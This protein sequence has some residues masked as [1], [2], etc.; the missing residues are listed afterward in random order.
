MINRDEERLT[1]VGRYMISIKPDFLPEHYQAR[2]EYTF[3]LIEHTLQRFELSV[4]LDFFFKTI[5]FAAIIGN[6][7]RHQEN[8][9]FITKTTNTTPYEIANAIYSKVMRTAPIYDS[10]SSLARE[11]NDERVSVM[12]SNEEILFKYINNGNSEIHWNKEKI[13][14]FKLIENLLN[15]AHNLQFRKSADFIANWDDL[16]IKQI[17]NAIDLN[18]SGE[19]KYYCIPRERKELIIKLLAIRAQKL[20]ELIN[21]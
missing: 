5:L 9:A 21:G 15:S 1:E 3:Q 14:H 10:G 17:I 19:W 6:T 11:L 18:L 8:W 7:D 13:S 16:S 20:K 2:K 4:H 12:L